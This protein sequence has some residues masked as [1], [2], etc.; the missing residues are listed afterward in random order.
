MVEI[1]ATLWWRSPTDV[2]RSGLLPDLTG[3]PARTA[4]DE[5]EEEGQPGRSLHGRLRALD[6][7]ALSATTDVVLREVATTAALTGAVLETRVIRLARPWIAPAPLVEL[8]A[9]DLWDAGFRVCFG[10]S[11]APVSDAAVALGVGEDAG[12]G[13]LEAF[14]L[15]DGP[16]EIVSR[17][18]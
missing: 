12:F 14:L 6:E 3:C 7:R 15:E 9:R 13:E 5:A 16:W 8:V 10:P 18:P 4:F 1:S 17:Q 11:W 2:P